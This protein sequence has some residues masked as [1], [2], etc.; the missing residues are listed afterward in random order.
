MR[1]VRKITLATAGALFVSVF[2]T[3]A[4]QVSAPAQN[5]TVPPLTGTVLTMERPK[6]SGVTR[7]G[8]RYEVTAVSA[9]QKLE[10]TDEMELDQPRVQLEFANGTTLALSAATGLMRHTMDSLSINRDVVL[11]ADSGHEIGLGEAT[12]DLRN[13]TVTSE[14][15]FEIRS[16]THLLRGRRLEVH[17]SGL[18]IAI[19][20]WLS[21]PDGVVHFDRYTVQSFR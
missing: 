14:T 4:A 12:I 16:G 2:F 8:R 5:A 11:L 19:D 6:Y 15:P 18:I 10:G 17:E 3:A 1:H 7:N 21:R 9:R 13:N 20:A